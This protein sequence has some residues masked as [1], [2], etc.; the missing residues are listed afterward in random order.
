MKT[1][2]QIIKEIE[3]LKTDTER[4]AYWISL[5]DE[6]RENFRAVITR[7][8]KRVVEIWRILYEVGFPCKN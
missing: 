5:S 8:V 4:M 6:E 7:M 3:E 1:S 2:S